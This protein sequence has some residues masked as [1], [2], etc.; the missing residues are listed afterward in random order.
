MDSSDFD[1][2]DSGSEGNVEE[3]DTKWTM[4]YPRKPMAKSS[5]QAQK[6][7][8]D[9]QKHESRFHGKDQNKDA[10][11]LRYIVEPA[12]WTEMQSYMKCTG[13]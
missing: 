9:A 6:L 1:E 4:V 13:E 12:T 8:D 11:N 5:K 3:Q 10:L 7:W 2:D